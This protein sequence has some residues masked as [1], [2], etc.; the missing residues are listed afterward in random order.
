[1]AISGWATSRAY[2]LRGETSAAC[3][4]RLTSSELQHLGRLRLDPEVECK[5]TVPRREQVAE[6][7]AKGCA[8]CERFIGLA[9]DR[10]VEKRVE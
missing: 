2:N 10:H 5:L 1:M 6:H 9:H 8:V 3:R 4:R 7:G